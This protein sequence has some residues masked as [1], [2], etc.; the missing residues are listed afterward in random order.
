M[1]V[2][3]SGVAVLGDYGVRDLRVLAKVSRDTG[4]TRRLLE[5]AAI[6]KG[7]SRGAQ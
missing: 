1:E 2:Y 7:V 5:L 4:Q 6:Y 3:V